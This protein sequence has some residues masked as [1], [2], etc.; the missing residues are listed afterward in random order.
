MKDLQKVGGVAALIQAA[1]YVVGI[2]LGVTLIFPLLNSDPA[3]YIAFLTDNQTLM[4]MWNLIS[5]WVSAIALVPPV[6]PE[7]A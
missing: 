2:V 7:T 6:F 4:H 1:A 3:Q 5:Y